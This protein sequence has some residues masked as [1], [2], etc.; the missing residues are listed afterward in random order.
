MK[1][2]LSL[3]VIAATFAGSAIAADLPSKKKPLAAPVVVSP[4][5]FVVGAG[6]TT[7]YISRGITQSNH[8]ASISATAEVNYAFSSTWQAYANAAGYSIKFSPTAASPSVELDTAAG[9]RGTFG[10]FTTDV[11]VIAYNYPN[12]PVG[13]KPAYGEIY[14][15]AGY[16]VTEAFSV[17]ANYF[18]SPNYA[19]LATNGQYVS[20]TAKYVLPANFAVSG[21]F[22]RQILGTTKN[23]GFLDAGTK[24]VSYNLYNAGVSYTYKFATLDARYYGTSLS[25]ANCLVDNAS[26]SSY[27]G[28]RFVGTLSFAFT[29][30]DVK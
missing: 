12:S 8:A 17:G 19:N 7:D 23:G 21:E 25:K 24:L 29:A 14:G 9:V 3:A 28:Q 6:I 4:W 30:K 16:A 15:K 2:I 1:K 13:P 20:V 27:C 26:L 11:G 10:A 22:G 5:D 18:Y